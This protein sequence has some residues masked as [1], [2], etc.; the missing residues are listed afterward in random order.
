VGREGKKGGTIKDVEIYGEGKSRTLPGGDRHE[1]DRTPRH[2][3][4]LPAL[5]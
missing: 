4:I 2:Q 5:R 3:E 1:K